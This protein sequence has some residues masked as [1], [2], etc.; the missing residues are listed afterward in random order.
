MCLCGLFS[1]K[2]PQI[3]SKTLSQNNRTKTGEKRQ[4][5]RG[6]SRFKANLVYIGSSRTARATQRNPVLKNKR[7]A[8]T[9]KNKK[10]L[11]PD[12]A[13]NKISGTPSSEYN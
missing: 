9:L 13:I 7:T 12:C 3:C 10:S 2:P 11:K 1:F 8:P 6:I 5:G 4:R